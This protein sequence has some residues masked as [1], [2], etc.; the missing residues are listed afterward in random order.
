MGWEI[1]VVDNNSSDETR[2][3][4]EDLQRMYPDRIRYL[5]EAQ[6]GISHARNSGIRNARG[7]ILAF[8]DDDETAGVDWLQN[9][10]ASYLTVN[11]PELEGVFCR[12]WNCARPQLAVGPK[13]FHLVTPSAVRYEARRL[14]TLPRVLSAR[15]WHLER[16][17]LTCVADSG[18]IWVVSAKAC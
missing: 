1:L 5:F 15:I 2:Q 8:I 18:P 12:L 16:K 4:V 10:T 17:C 13:P 9:L 6:Q 7:E 14:E 3:V 11:G